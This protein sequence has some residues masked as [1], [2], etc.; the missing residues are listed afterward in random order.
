MTRK[1]LNELTLDQLADERD[2]LEDLINKRV[3]KMFEQKRLELYNNGDENGIRNL[4]N[5]IPD[6]SEK[7]RYYQS[8]VEI[9]KSKNENIIF[10]K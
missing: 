8:I 9:K 1:E 4:L 10:S 2:A 5:K 7:F 3:R 6:C